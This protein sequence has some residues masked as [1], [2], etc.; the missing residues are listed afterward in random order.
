MIDSATY[1]RLRQNYPFGSVRN[2]ADDQDIDVPA[3]EY[4]PLDMLKKG[5]A[6]LY[7]PSKVLDSILGEDNANIV[8]VGDYGSGKSMTMRELFYLLKE[9]HL[10]SQIVRFPVY[11]NLRD[12]F[13]QSDPAEALIRHANSIGMADPN[14]LVAGW[15]AG[16]VL[17]FLDGFDEVSSARLVRGSEKIKQARRQAVRLVHEFVEQSPNRGKVIITGREHYFDSHNE[18]VSAL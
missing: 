7:V 3:T 4:V 8:I 5:T 1:L 13:G 18:L 10:Q 2:P 15:R 16:F 14:Q 11:L 12:H 17:L 9:K 6:E